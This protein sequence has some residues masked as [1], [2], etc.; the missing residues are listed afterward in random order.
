MLK[1]VSGIVIVGII[2]ASVLIS[3]KVDLHF[4]HHLSLPKVNQHLIKTTG[5]IFKT[6]HIHVSNEFRNTD[7]VREIVKVLQEA[8][9]TDTIIF[10]IAGIGGEVETVQYI[11][12]NVKESEAYIIMIVEAP[13]YS[14]HAYLAASG[15]KL[16][17]LPGTYL[18]FHT[19][20]AYGQ[21]C[22]KYTGQDRKVSN[23]EHCERFMKA[24]LTLL[25]Q[26]LKSISFLTLAEKQEITS[27]HSVY[28]SA[29]EYN[30]RT[31]KF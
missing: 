13:S 22:K 9:K 27:G 2:I 21:D 24:H 26:F 14:A 29:A 17:M 7:S 3:G 23:M 8:N 20:S 10:H 1:Q 18:M 28:I 25:H 5:L 19:S 4:N 12:N 15:D 16:K 6:T 31:A 30:K 11:I